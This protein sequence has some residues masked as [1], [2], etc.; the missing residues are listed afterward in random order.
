M[1]DDIL[2]SKSFHTEFV[3]ASEEKRQRVI[4]QMFSAIINHLTNTET[5]H[6]EWRL[7]VGT[8]HTFI[9]EQERKGYGTPG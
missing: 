7:T 2:S 9:P 3:L 6:A 5:E 4:E 1:F 8:P